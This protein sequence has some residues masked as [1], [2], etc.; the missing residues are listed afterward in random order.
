MLAVKGIQAIYD[1]A[2]WIYSFDEFFEDELR[3]VHLVELDNG[4]N[5]EFQALY[6]DQ[7]LLTAKIFSLSS[8]DL[9]NIEKLKKAS[10]LLLAANAEHSISS[11]ITDDY[12][13]LELVINT[14]CLSDSQVL[15]F[16]QNFMDYCDI[17]IEKMN[18]LDEMLSN[19]YN[20]VPFEF[21]IN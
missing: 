16:T 19:Y 18:E 20:K 3:K 17:F 9:K 6:K 13:Q 7:I 21:L 10:Q 5:I 4:L 8:D 1:E 12:Y 11:A 14:S 2:G 15:Y